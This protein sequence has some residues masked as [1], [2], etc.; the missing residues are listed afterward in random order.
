MTDPS[1][2]DAALACLARG[3][4]V[5]PAAPRAKHPIVRWQ[6]FQTKMPSEETVRGWFGKWPD[7]NL[8]VVTG[9]IS[10]L[11]VLDVDPRHDG[12]ESL[13]IIEERHGPLPETVEAITGGGGRHVYFA[14][15]EAEIRNRAGF[16]PGLDLRGEGGVIIVPPSVHPSG[17]PYRWRPG[18]DPDEIALAPF[19]IYLLESRFGGEERLG[20]P[21][22]YWRALARTGVGEGER[23]STIASFAGHLLWHG[24][25]P[26]VALELLLG[27]NRMRCTPP[28]DDE[29]VIRTVRSI[30][31]T[32]RSRQSRDNV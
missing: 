9:L 11:I 13:R 2:L 10:N 16:A 7:A 15:P 28:L 25:D 32:Q 29:E 24:V 31:H 3:W 22:A 1:H 23:N 19:P 5:I 6:A 27:W 30:E 26:D 4:A 14:C 20:R 21:M 12:D 8:A 18:H 17:K